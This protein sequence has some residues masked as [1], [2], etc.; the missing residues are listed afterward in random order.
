[1]TSDDDEFPLEDG[2]RVAVTLRD[3]QL[4]VIGRARKFSMLERP[5]Q[6]ADLLADFAHASAIGRAA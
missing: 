3:S 6:L 4:E 1:L 2:R 5:G